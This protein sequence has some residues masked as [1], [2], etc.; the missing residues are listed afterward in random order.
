M[1]KLIKMG[2]A[3]ISGGLLF[4]LA[5]V[6]M[7]LFQVGIEGML[8]AV[9][10]VIISIGGIFAV[11]GVIILVGRLMARK[12]SAFAKEIADGDKKV[13][14]LVDDERNIAI[15]RRASAT[16]HNYMNWL[17]SPLLIFLIMMQVELVVTLVF[18][19]VMVAKAIMNI[20]LH[21]KYNKQM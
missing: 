3:T 13:D 15:S 11:N 18:L 7:L 5:G 6:V 9:P 4:S 14:I 20:L 8:I 1:K 21:R 2:L 19:A 16:T 17:N 10:I 12:G